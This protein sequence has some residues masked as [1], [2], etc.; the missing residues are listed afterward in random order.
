MQKVSNLSNQKDLN[1]N[2]KTENFVSSSQVWGELQ[3]KL[4]DLPLN[5]VYKIFTATFNANTNAANLNLNSGFNLNSNTNNN[6][7]M[8]TVE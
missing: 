7:S 5:E 6:V 2:K 4:I 1:V 3:P 8:T